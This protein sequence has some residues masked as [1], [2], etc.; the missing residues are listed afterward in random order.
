[1]PWGPAEGHL[2]RLSVSREAYSIEV[3]TVWG[4]A[5][6]GGAAGCLVAFKYICGTVPNFYHVCVLVLSP[7][8]PL[9]SCFPCIKAP[10]A[11]HKK[12]RHR[13]AVHP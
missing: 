6:I 12:P 13:L 10:E 1:M 7:V 11:S 8:F 3:L 5:D 2:A 9:V 4:V